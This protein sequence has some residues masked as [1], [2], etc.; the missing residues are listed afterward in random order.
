[1]QSFYRHLLLTG[2]YFFNVDNRN[3]SRIWEISEAAIVDVL[4]NRCFEKS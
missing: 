3:V 4:Q 2:I 1:M